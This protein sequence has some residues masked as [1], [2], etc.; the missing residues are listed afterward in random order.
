[1][2]AVWR[3]RG[4]VSLDDTN[5]R[6]VFTGWWRNGGPGLCGMRSM[7]A[8]APGLVGWVRLVECEQLTVGPMAGRPHSQ[9]E[10]G[11]RI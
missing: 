9:G 4:C 8:A 6:R 5:L 3:D 10:P 7:S 1:M 11:F 2:T